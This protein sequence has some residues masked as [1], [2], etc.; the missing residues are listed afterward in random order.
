[1]PGIAHGLWTPSTISTLAL[2]LNANRLAGNDGDA[3]G[4]WTN[5]SP[6]GTAGDFTQATGSKK[7]VLKRNTI[8]GNSTVLFDGV[9]DALTSTFTIANGATSIYCVFKISNTGLI[10]QNI[11][12]LLS[13]T[14]HY[15]VLEAITVGGVYTPYSI[16]SD[17]TSSTN[18]VGISDTLNTNPHIYSIVYNAGGNSLPSAYTISVDGAARTVV[19]SGSFS[20]T[21]ASTSCIGARVSGTSSI[22]PFSG[23]IARLLV[24]NTNLSVSDNQLVITYL[25]NIYGI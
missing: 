12:Q 14:P 13:S 2:D 8:N 18:S 9:D 20:G 3:V 1:M 4:T 7:P 16:Q 5:Y 23:H 17:G 24:F 11:Y 6:S 22:I 21:A 25:R 10:A 19:T 15:S